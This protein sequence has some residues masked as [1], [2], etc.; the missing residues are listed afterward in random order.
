MSNPQYVTIDG[1]KQPLMTSAKLPAK[2]CCCGGPNYCNTIPFSLCGDATYN[3]CGYAEF[4]NPSATPPVTA[5]CPPKFYRKKTVHTVYQYHYNYNFTGGNP[6]N[7]AGVTEYLNT[8][9]VSEYPSDPTDPCVAVHTSSGTASAVHTS[10][11]DWGDGTDSVD[12]ECSG[13]L[14][15]GVWESTTTSTWAATWFD[16]PPPLTTTGAS[17]C[18]EVM[19]FAN[20]AV[21]YSNTVKTQTGS[22]EYHYSITDITANV[23]I[24]TTLSDEI[25]LHDTLLTHAC[26]EETCADHTEA[27]C[28]PCCTDESSYRKFNVTGGCIV[29]GT[30]AVA[31]DASS[32]TTLARSGQTSRLSVWFTDLEPDKTYRATLHFKRSE[33]D[34]DEGGHYLTPTCSSGVSAG[35]PF[36]IASQTI[37]FS[38]ADDYH[39]AEV[40]SDN[41]DRCDIMHKLC[42]LNDEA[43]AWNDANPEATPRTVG[44]SAGSIDVP[45]TPNHYTWLESCTFEEITAP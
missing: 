16:P 23:I 34:K 11:E 5:S 38:T 6:K 36:D 8:I 15:N 22:Y 7:T 19:S 30:S 39:W 24:T 9:E 40:I 44:C 31:W 35:T 12:S 29:P 41:C 4:T 32:C 2:E 27:G 13:T 26:S 3:G 20:S 43:A 21:V 17:P 28:E 33:F 18:C 42:E 14:L 25:T 37:E 10:S 45:A 1:K